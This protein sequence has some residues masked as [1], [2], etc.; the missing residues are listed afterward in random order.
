MEWV[1]SDFSIVIFGGAIIALAVGLAA[2]RNR[3]DSIAWP[4]ALL[5]FA[6]TAWAIPH[7]ISLG[8][9]SVE[10]VAFWNK[11]RYPGTV[12]AP[13][14]YLVVILKYAGY[15]QKLSRSGYAGL[16]LIPTLTIFIVWTN[17]YHGLFWGSLSI[18]T[19][20]GASIFVP[21]FG[22]WYWL[23]LSYL[24][25]ITVVG[26]VILAHQVLQSSRV[27]RK[28]A[29]VMFMGG[30]V[31]L[32]V[33]AAMNFGIGPDPM[34]DLTT[35]ALAVSGLTFALAL[36]RLDLL[37]IR[38]VAWRQLIGQLDDGVVVVGPE[39]QIRDFNPTA[40]RILGDL[41][42]DRPIEKVHPYGDIPNEGEFNVEIGERTRSFRTRETELTDES[43]Q[44]I[45][46]IIYLNDI[47]DIARR[48]QRISVLN[49]I[50]R[51]NIRNELN[52]AIGQLKMVK[53]QLS[54][55][56]QENVESAVEAI[57][58]II[59]LAEKARH[60]EQT[61]ENEE[62]LTEV[63]VTK[64][65]EQVISNA[66]QSYP[67]ATIEYHPSTEFETEQMIRVV[68]EELFAMALREL[69]E[70]GIVHND[71]ESRCVTVRIESVDGKTNVMV[72]DNGS[73]IPA[74]EKEI[75]TEQS[76]TALEH[77]SGIG[78]WLVKWMTSL[79]GGG[80]SFD[81]NGSQGNIV[82]LTLPNTTNK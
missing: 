25:L 11:L 59:D 31:P 16:A 58:R 49:R 18:K 69:V 41:A 76:E 42:P 65:A 68:D 12:F 13:V 4:L 82:T 51:H 14:L 47:T 20:G 1:L 44:S 19:K 2:L 73:G 81:Q 27:F 28:Q 10:K 63:S 7:A 70:N 21:T 39:G 71:R 37:E 36:F 40:E 6:V 5:M 3:H 35:T 15:D 74:M 22:P 48:E 17:H 55:G 78:L 57:H 75:L 46:K 52:V 66:R 72:S 8:F 64:I 32:A 24:Y 33:N 45:G 9:S 61:L 43:G 26:L 79:S 77:G 60:V 30:I 80:L 67:D 34:V 38:P 62:V 29:A 53:D 23:N 54:P 50:L 56:E